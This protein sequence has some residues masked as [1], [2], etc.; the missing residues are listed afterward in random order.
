[1]QNL[2]DRNVLLQA[3]AGFLAKDVV[4][5]IDDRGVAF[6]VRIAAHL[7]ATV[8]RELTGDEARDEA[9]VVRLA[10]ALDATVPIG[11]E[12][13]DERHQILRALEIDLA[14]RIRQTDPDSDAALGLRR[15]VQEDLK[16]RLKVVNPRFDVSP[17]VEGEGLQ[18]G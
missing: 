8:A 5:A 9:Q 16:A 4:A 18:P 11:L 17:D 10:T 15:L 7:V 2:P 13:R 14:R 12:T 3:V 6:R 1:M